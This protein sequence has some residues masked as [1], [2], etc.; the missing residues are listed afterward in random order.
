M[1][2][3]KRGDMDPDVRAIC[4]QLRVTRLV[5]GMT[6]KRLCSKAGFGEDALRRWE[7]GEW[8]PDHINLRLWAEAL[9]YTVTYDIV[10][11]DNDE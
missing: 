10:P 8:M 3:L 9:G 4:N 5:I 2:H 6:A 7:R 11:K 1:P